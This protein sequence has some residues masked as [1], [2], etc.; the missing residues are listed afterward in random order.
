M[1]KYAVVVDD[2]AKEKKAS[3]GGSTC[4]RCGSLLEFP[5]ANVPKCPKCGTSPFERAPEGK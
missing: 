2:D 4:P 3:E 5:E 1:D